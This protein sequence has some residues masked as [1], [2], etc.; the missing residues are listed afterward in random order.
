MPLCQAA[1]VFKTTLVNPQP[2]ME[3]QNIH[4]E[5]RLEPINDPTMRV[6][7]FFNDRPLT[8]GSRFKT[9]NDFGFI[10]LD[11]VGVTTNDQGTYVCKATNMLGQAQTNASVQVRFFVDRLC[12]FTTP[13]V[14]SICFG[15]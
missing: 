7:W 14:L 13:L 8:I 5:A 3:G 4:L 12:T 10:A 9:Y 1:P 15:S 6:E 2:V 11:I